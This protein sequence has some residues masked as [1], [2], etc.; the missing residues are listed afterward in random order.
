M[1]SQA[2]GIMSNSPYG[3]E[4]GKFDLSDAG[5]LSLQ[6]RENYT[7]KLTN[8]QKDDVLNGSLTNDN[9]NN[10]NNNNNAEEFEDSNLSVTQIIPVMFDNRLRNVMFK[11]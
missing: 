4:N 5:D 1:R 6:L 2:Y 3:L 9:N 8:L 10:N 11:I 7:E